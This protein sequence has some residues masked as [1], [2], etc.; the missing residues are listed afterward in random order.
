MTEPLSNRVIQ[1]IGQAADLNNRLFPL[2]LM[3]ATEIVQVRV[4]DHHIISADGVFSFKK[5]GL[6]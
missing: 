6:L 4:L 3:I 2:S 1:T 5:A